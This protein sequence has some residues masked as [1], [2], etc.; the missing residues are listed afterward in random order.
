MAGPRVPSIPLNALDNIQDRNVYAVLRAL[1]DMMN[2]RNGQTGDSD[3]AFVTRAELG[4]LRAGGILVGVPGA[5]QSQGVTPQI[6]RPADIA[7]VINDLQALVIES[8]LFKAL[9][10]RI[11]KVDAPGTGVIAQLDEERTVR[12]T[13]VSALVDDVTTLTAAVNANTVA[14]ETEATVRADAD[15][16][17]MG[18]Y[19]VKIDANG[20]VTG[21]GLISTANN[22]TPFSEFMVRADRFSIAS[23]SGPGITP[24]VPFIVLTTPTTVNGYYVPAGVYMDSAMMKV[25]SV[26]EAHI[27][28][29][30]IREAHLQYGIID[31]LHVKAAA[32]KYA[33]IG[34]AEVDT[35]KIRGNA[36]VVPSAAT[37]TGDVTL[38]FYSTG[39]PVFVTYSAVC[40]PFGDPGGDAVSFATTCQFDG[41]TVASFGKADY[42][43]FPYSFTTL[44]YPGAG[45]HTARMLCGPTGPITITALEAKR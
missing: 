30:A 32:I 3:S 22:S 8:P 35:L 38:T 31:T 13:A 10:E 37:G 20:Y 5:Q 23:P 41:S 2:V 6:I 19:S 21:F 9:G 14:L 42:G 36:V 28:F 4:N 15:G 45:W 39:Q 16:N 11:N 24:K 40:L 18:K 25:A 44:V 17:I 43:Q 33:N 26:G 1:T 29:A 34:D 7:R 12:S 27:D